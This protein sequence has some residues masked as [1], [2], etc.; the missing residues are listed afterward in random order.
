[1]NLDEANIVRVGCLNMFDLVENRIGIVIRQAG[2]IRH[3]EIRYA[4]FND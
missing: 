2:K 4:H 3:V 1:M